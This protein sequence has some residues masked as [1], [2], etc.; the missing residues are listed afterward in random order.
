MTVFTV[1]G[2]VKRTADAGRYQTFMSDAT[3]GYSQEIVGVYVDGG[4]EDCGSSPSDQF[5]WAYTK[6][7]GGWFFQCSGVSATLNIWHHIAVTRDAANVTRIFI[8]GVLRNTLTGTAPPTTSTGAFAL[9]TA[10]DAVTEFFAGLLDE[11]RISNVA[12]YSASFTPQ[13]TPFVTDANT[14]A[15]YHLDEGTGQVLSDASGNNRHGTLGT[16][17][18]VEAV[19]PVWSSDAP[20]H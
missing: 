1:E 20:V 17:A 18:A 12:R 11:V 2:W 13:T 19:D 9:G 8:N 15:L 16:S 14:V 3:N 4:N 6:V 10:G 5:A 7:G